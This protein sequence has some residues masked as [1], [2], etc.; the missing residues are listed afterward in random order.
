MVCVGNRWYKWH[1][2]LSICP[3]VAP[4]PGI[5]MYMKSGSSVCWQEVTACFMLASVVNQL[6]NRCFLSS[7]NTWKLQHWDY[8]GVAYNLPVS[9]PVGCMWPNNYQLFGPHRK[10]LTAKQFVTDANAKHAVTSW[11][12]TL[13]TDFFYTVTQALVPW[14]NKRLNVDRE[15]CGGMMCTIWYHMPRLHRTQE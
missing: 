7:P 3:T 4:S 8:K 12:Q 2:H 13:D 14:R 5:T 1:L 6:P 15:L 11:L 9:S 10:H